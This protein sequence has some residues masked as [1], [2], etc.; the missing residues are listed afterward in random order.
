M[1]STE[2]FHEAYVNVTYVPSYIGAGDGLEDLLRHTHYEDSSHSPET[3][4]NS[5]PLTNIAFIHPSLRARSQGYATVHGN[6]G[7]GYQRFG[8]TSIQDSWSAEG[9]DTLEL[10]ARRVF[11]PDTTIAE[12]L[13]RNLLE[14][15]VHKTQELIIGSMRYFLNTETYSTQLE[16]WV[17]ET[18]DANITVNERL[19]KY[20]WIDWK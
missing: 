20:R 7:Q 3:V 12:N 18:T 19:E 17:H 2:F 9:H 4:D 1:T 6:H 8:D 16:S 13:D 15:H 14:P 10:S 11:G 5:S